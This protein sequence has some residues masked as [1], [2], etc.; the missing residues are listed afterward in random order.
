MKRSNFEPCLIF[1]RNEAAKRNKQVESESIKLTLMLFCHHLVHFIRN[2]IVFTVF[3]LLDYLVKP[4]LYVN[5]SPHTKHFYSLV[6]L[7]IYC[8]EDWTVNVFFVAY[9]CI[10]FK[11]YHKYA[12]LVIANRCVYLFS[13][14]HCS[15][16]YLIDEI[17]YSFPNAVDCF[18]SSV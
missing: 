17:N 13:C 15:C 18:S 8:P 11:D 14:I 5:T 16:W 3:F 10:D 12:S 7:F 2:S 6:C 1:Q 4:W 9:Y